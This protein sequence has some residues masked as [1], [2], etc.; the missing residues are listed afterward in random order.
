MLAWIIGSCYTG[1]GNTYRCLC[2]LSFLGKEEPLM[3]ST[4]EVFPTNILY[5]TAGCQVF[6]NAFGNLFLHCAF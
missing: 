4:H 3:R 1:G 2:K 6:L 5:F